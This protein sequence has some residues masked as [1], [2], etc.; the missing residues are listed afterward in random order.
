MRN[1][2]IFSL[3]T[4]I[5]G[6]F[7]SLT[8]FADAPPTSQLPAHEQA[9]ANLILGEMA[10]EQN[11]VDTAHD[12]Y[13]A[14]VELSHDPDVAKR[15][16]YLALMSGHI[17]MALNAAKEWAI[18]APK[19]VEAQ[20]INLDLL[21]KVHQTAAAV[22]YLQQALKVGDKNTINSVISELQDAPKTLQQTLL[23]SILQLP[24]NQ[25]SEPNLQVI[26]SLLQFQTGNPQQAIKTINAVLS[27]RPDWPQPIALKADYLIN[28]D[29]INQA[30]AFTAAKAKQY[31]NQPMIQLIDAEM[32]LKA[33]Q[34]EAAINKLQAL[35]AFP[36]TRGIA[37]LT[38]AQLA[39]H[40]KD[41]TNAAIYLKEAT[42]D[43][44]QADTAYY[45]LG[46]IYQFEHKTDE[47]IQ[48]YQHVADG[49]HYVTAQL[50]AAALLANK[51]Q[52]QQ[53]LELLSNIKIDNMNQAKEVILL[54]VQLLMKIKQTPVALQV[55][56]K[57][58][59]AIPNDI[60]LLYARSM[61]ANALNDDEQSEKDL[62][63]ILVLD[64]NQTTALNALGYL[65]INTPTRYQEA[66]DYTQRALTLAPQNPA[67]LDT[68]GWL[69]YHM[70]NYQSAYHYLN[71]A[72]H[73]D[74]DGVI[75]AHYGEVLWRMGNKPAAK[76]VWQGALIKFPDDPALLDTIK[77]FSENKPQ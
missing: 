41:M 8:S 12:Y 60:E 38:L 73:I 69:Q 54:Q 14:A 44:L 36:E 26:T 2:L 72:Y 29:Q 11:Q 24:A 75:A 49:Q 25:Q 9:I 28:T 15:T 76:E 21:L 56:N 53:A 66:L 37:L 27:V 55:L 34:Q 7:V 30:L 32:L 6:S 52:N 65:L 42:S 58:I 19:D 45:L 17:N 13:L 10:I 18:L 64:P 59:A 57:A 35:K 20:L 1:S 31:P 51:N 77:R 39:L 23:G 33:K 67:I 40:N 74:Y 48:A 43:P 63:E 3:I 46:E 68:M 62:K 50:K 70:G 16:V 22:P 47:A 71:R 5:V 61:V 4:G